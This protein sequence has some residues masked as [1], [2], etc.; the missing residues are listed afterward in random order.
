MGPPL[1]RNPGEGNHQPLS[2]TA[3]EGGE[4]SEPGE[5]VSVGSVLAET[6]AALGAAGIDE[7]RRH[8]RR[9]IAAALDLSA[10][11]VFG[12]PERVLDAAQIARIAAVRARVVA[13][14][15]LSR[16]LGRRE[17]WGLDLALSPDTLDPRPESETIVEAI[18]ARL[19]DRACACRFLDLGTGSGCLLLAL[20]AE[21]PMSIGLGI[22]IAAGAVA[23]ARRNAVAVGLADRAH[24]IVGDWGQAAAGGWHAIV[25]NPP[26]IATS[27]LAVLPPEV[28][29]HDPRRALDGGTDGLAAYRAIAAELPRLVGAGGLFAGEVGAGQGPA[30]AALLA[31]TGLAV[32]GVIPDLAGIPRCVV[33]HRPA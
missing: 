18:L 16:I 1:S 32:E 22:D 20:L 14:E 11:E 17:F 13:R 33:V 10:A 29:D 4:C 9:L 19:S 12:H 2:R 15:P 8:A 26:Y 27:E 28:R 30:V 21:F 7:P 24:F 5:G 23:T 6:A 31:A 3:G 25:A